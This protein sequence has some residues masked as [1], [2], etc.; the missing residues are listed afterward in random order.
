MFS[1]PFKSVLSFRRPPLAAAALLLGCII[2]SAEAAPPL[3]PLARWP[4]L[5]LLALYVVSY[6][7]AG[8]AGRRRGARGKKRGG[9]RKK[10]GVRTVP[11]P[12]D[13]QM[14]HPHN[15]RRRLVCCYH[16]KQRE[17]TSLGGNNKGRAWAKGTAQRLPSNKPRVGKLFHRR[18]ASFYETRHLQ[19]HSPDVCLLEG[20]RGPSTAAGGWM[21]LPVTR[22]EG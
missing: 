20:A 1:C 18:S 12:R 21:K 2:F 15:G 16:R 3:S 17:H 22:V 10:G 14:D 11:L 5:L 9:A 4:P 19:E 7:S 6:S 13:N 8:R